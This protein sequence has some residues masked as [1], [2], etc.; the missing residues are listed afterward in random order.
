MQNGWEIT[1]SRPTVS[2]EDQC[3]HSK[4]LVV[5]EGKCT[6]KRSE[7]QMNWGNKLCRTTSE[8]A[9]VQRTQPASYT[10]S[11]ASYARLHR[12]LEL[13]DH[14]TTTLLW[15]RT[16][17]EEDH[18]RC[19]ASAKKM[20]RAE[21]EPSKRTIS[22]KQQRAAMSAKRAYKTNQ[23]AGENQSERWQHR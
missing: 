20:S 13:N 12:L 21:L 2:N 8:S 18:R 5:K 9:P 15:G 4:V 11:P 6:K 3:D 23:T 14:K 19:K 1:S 7:R 10:W 22:C 16:V 17:I